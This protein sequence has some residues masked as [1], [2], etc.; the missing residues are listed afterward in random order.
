MSK[1]AFENIRRTIPGVVAA[2]DLSANQFRFVRV[3]NIAVVPGTRNGLEIES[4]AS[5]GDQAVG[6]LQ[7]KP[8]AGEAATVAITGSVT[9]V[10]ASVAIT[11]GA[12]VSA[13]ADG[14]ATTSNTYVVGTCLTASTAANEVISVYLNS[15]GLL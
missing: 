10:I 8:L 12:D 11:A 1:N 15:E 4:V 14:R 2:D 7:N 13:A 3:K 6:V 5:L 9:K